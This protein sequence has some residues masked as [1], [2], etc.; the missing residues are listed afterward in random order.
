MC[1]SYRCRLLGILGFLS[2][3]FSEATAC[4]LSKDEELILFPTLGHLEEDGRTWNISIHGWIF[5]PES[6]SKKRAVALGLL[7]KALQLGNA[8]IQSDLFQKRVRLFLVD[9]ERDKKISIRLGNRTYDLPGSGPDGHFEHN[10]RTPADSDALLDPRRAAAAGWLSFE[11]PACERTV[12]RFAGRVQLV[13]PTGLSLISDIDDTIKISEVRDRTALVANTFLREYRAVTGMSELYARWQDAGVRFHYV[14][15]SPWQLFPALA[16]F[17]EKSGF[18]AGSH[19]LRPVRVKDETVLDLFKP[20]QDYKI[21]TIRALF[22]RFP[23]RRFILVGDSGERDPEIYGE[24]ARAF[25]NQIET[26]YI[27]NVTPGED[28]PGR[29][30]KAFHNLPSQRWQLFT[31]P[32]EIKIPNDHER[33]LHP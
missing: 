5:E 14:S 23:G 10:L 29:C 4:D 8:E 1:R 30:Q 12:R 22:E 7:A 19:N 25:Q 21:Q 28:T 3:A 17:L 9:N 31:D 18:P 20:P 27:R 16:D 33:G 32:A 11:G 24:I 6:D 13:P 2:L 15:A 26:I